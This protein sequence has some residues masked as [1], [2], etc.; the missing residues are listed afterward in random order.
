MPD[1]APRPETGRL[2]AHLALVGRA[3]DDLLERGSDD[4]HP[5]RA[6]W[7]AALSG[8]L[9]ERG[10]GAEAVLRELTGT[11]V[12]NGGRFSDPGF[13]GW[14]T[15]GPTTVPVAAAAAA[16]V[17]GP[18]RYSLTAFNL[19]EEMGL[20]WLAELC[21]L[22][23]TMRGVFSSGG[24]TANLVALGAA[25]QWAF[26]RVGVDV[27]AEGT[28]GRPVA[29][30][31]SEEAHHTVNRSLGVLGLGRSSLRVIPVDDGQ[32]MR[33]DALRAALARDR[34]AGVLP[35]AV[36]ASAG[37]TNTGVVDPLRAIG[38]AARAA[39]AWFHVD[40]AYGL[41]GV[42]DPRVAHLYDGLDLADSAIV[43]PHKW[44]GAP[45]GVAATF[46]RDRAILERAFTQEPSAYL[47]ESFTDV[48]PRS[49][50]DSIG[51]PYGDM[52][53]ELS[54]PSRGVLVWA[55]L[56]EIGRE[57]MR[58]RVMEDRDRA[59]RL[60]ALAEA[61]P[62]L[63]LLTPPVLSVCCLRHRG[64][65]G[66]DVDDLNRE[67]VRRLLRDTPYAP[68]STTV[69]GRFAIRPCFINARTRDEDVDGLA[70]AIV[71]IGDAL[72]GAD[73]GSAGPLSGA[74]AGRSAAGA[75]GHL[76]GDHRE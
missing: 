39:G 42:L 5:R 23:D 7:E 75:E 16:A 36:V 24:S 59:A 53:V 14:I 3:L 22:P 48:P 56:R 1:D 46:V 41:P 64:A 60:A 40:G 33:V 57:G 8:G 10:V 38:E 37:T 45:V 44:L 66:R 73:G 55:I 31:A 50:L 70:E 52:G 4:P 27:A 28:G 51:I 20:V 49:S 72:A 9:P 30:Y 6:V 68:S 58:R 2:A 19:L 71:R 26:E 69:A 13:L 63:E 61:H 74:R 47:E 65:G 35:V 32:A 18:Q 21:G 76:R 67:V 17:A 54:S 62:R 43:D 11:V 25:R 29:V 12:P 15:C 34:A